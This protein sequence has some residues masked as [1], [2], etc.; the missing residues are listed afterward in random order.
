[1]FSTHFVVKKCHIVRKMSGFTHDTTNI[2]GLYFVENVLSGTESQ[3]LTIMYLSVTK[4]LIAFTRVFRSLLVLLEDYRTTS[5][6]TKP[7]F[8][9]IYSALA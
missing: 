9:L 3:V 4:L 5:F 8:Y 2:V 7:H 1:M 6:S